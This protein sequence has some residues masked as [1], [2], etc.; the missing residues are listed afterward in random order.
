MLGRDGR[1]QPYTG[2]DALKPVLFGD[3]IGDPLAGDNDDSPGF[4]FEPGER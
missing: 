3:Q 1:W 4:G 2:A